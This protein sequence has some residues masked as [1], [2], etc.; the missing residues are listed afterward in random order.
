M[1]T[2]DKMSSAFARDG[3]TYDIDRKSLSDRVGDYLKNL[4]LSGQLKGGEK[5]P[6]SK[7]A[8]Q[9]G[10]SR[11]PIREA[12][13][14]LE[15]YGLIT[16]KPRSFASVV[17]LQPDEAEDVA[18]VRSALEALSVGTLARR[19]TDADFDAIALIV[20]E[21]EAALDAGDVAKVFEKDSVLH[22]EMAKRSENKHLY[23]LMRKLDAK[24]QLLRLV[25]RLP[26]EHLQVFVRQHREILAALRKRDAEACSRIMTHH[27]LD[28]LKHYTIAAA[29]A[30]SGLRVSQHEALQNPRSRPG[31]QD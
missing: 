19:G 2:T 28:Q 4:I 14:K 15:E 13:K 30:H 24:V 5:V 25:L 3:V 17:L 1:K 21:C 10:V 11:T 23:E 8:E 29:A 7:V 16:V 22:L 6:E 26:M 18:S 31:E 27:V 9:F 12:L 20:D